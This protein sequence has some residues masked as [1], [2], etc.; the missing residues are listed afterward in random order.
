MQWVDIDM[1]VGKPLTENPHKGQVIPGASSGPVTVL[2]LF[3]VTSE[4]NSV[5]MHIHGV[6]SYFYCNV[7]PQFNGSPQVINS[8]PTPLEYIYVYTMSISVVCITYVL[9]VLCI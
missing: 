9:G 6:T 3:G 2:R 4:G 7:P 5:L 8:A 1:Y